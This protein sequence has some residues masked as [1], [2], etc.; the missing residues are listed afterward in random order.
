MGPSTKLEK[1]IFHA[2]TFAA[3]FQFIDGCG[4]FGHE[5]SLLFHSDQPHE[6]RTPTG[7][8]EGEFAFADSFVRL[9]CREIDGAYVTAAKSSL[10]GVSLKED[11]LTADYLEWGIE[12][13]YRREWYD[14][15]DKPQTARI[16]PLDPVIRNLRID[17]ELYEPDVRPFQFEK[18][19]REKYFSGEGET[20]EPLGCADEKRSIRIP[21]FGIV[22]FL[23]W[24]WLPPNIHTRAKTTQ[25]VQLLRFDLKNPGTGGG[26]GSVGNGTPFGGK[27]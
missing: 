14:D 17:G 15:P 23:D 20:I 11:R 27:K 3:H 25:K 22:Y 9:D 8:R 6:H 26:P 21:D 12:T 1:Y 19:L 16:L 5:Y 7:R 18:S 13:V 10:T 4:D 2:E 24:I